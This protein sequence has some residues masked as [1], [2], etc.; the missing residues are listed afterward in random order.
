[1]AAAD[2]AL[3]TVRC[4]VA[5]E[6]PPLG[7]GALVGP[8][9][10]AQM[11][12]GFA[13]VRTLV[14]RKEHAAA[15]RARA[16]RR[17][18]SAIVAGKHARDA[19]PGQRDSTCVEPARDGRGAAARH[20][21]GRGQWWR[22]CDADTDCHR[23][24][25]RGRRRKITVGRAGGGGKHDGQRAGPRHR[26]EAS[27]N[28]SSTQGAST[29]SAGWRSFAAPRATR[30]RPSFRRWRASMRSDCSR[31]H[32][33][34]LHAGGHPARLRGWAGR[35]FRC[36]PARAPAAIRAAADRR[37]ISRRGS[38]VTGR[39]RR[40]RGRRQRGARTRTDRARRRA[41]RAG[42]GGGAG[43]RERGEPVEQGTPR[44]RAC[45]GVRG[46]RRRADAR[47]RGASPPRRATRRQRGRRWASR[48]A[49]ATSI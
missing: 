20:R 3:A 8:V 18:P 49:S 24:L 43:D 40:Q 34:C 44:A 10:H 21:R 26:S 11:L 35:H 5:G 47:P 12:R 28:R 1:M 22:G 33:R 9:A 16:A 25:L 36:R 41:A 30:K 27:P 38:G 31:V 14:R 4:F 29:F 46:G 19:W 42:R 17:A 2:L 13:R 48:A 45:A 7:S 23:C 39:T 32:P 6:V 37:S 15:L